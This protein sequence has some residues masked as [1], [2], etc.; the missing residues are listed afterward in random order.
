MTRLLETV[1]LSRRQFLKGAGA[2]VVTF[3]LPVTLNP[4]LADAAEDKAAKE[5]I[6]LD[7]VDSWLAIGQDGSITA[8]VGKV[9]VGMGI[10]TA[11]MQIVAEE[12]DVPLERV[13]ILMGDTETTPDQG[14][15]GSSNGIMTGGEA[16]RKAAAHAHHALLELAATRLNAPVDQLSVKD[17]VVSVQAAPTKHV[18]YGELIGGKRFNL[19]VP[20]KVKTKDPAQYTVVGKP[21]KRIDIPPI[22]TARHTYI[23]DVRVPGMLHGRI[24]RPPQAGA[25]PVSVDRSQKIPGLVKIVANKDFLAVVTEQEWQAVR[26]AREL[27]V[28]WSQPAARFPNSYEELYP[29]MAKMPIESSKKDAANTGDVDAALA[30]AAQTFEAVYEYPFQSHAS[31]GPACAIADV[32]NGKATVWFGGQKPYRV[33]KAIAELLAIPAKNVRVLWYPGPGSYGTNDADDAAA[34]AALLSHAIGKPVR[35]QWMRAEGTGWDPKGPAQIIRMRGGL[36]KD[37]NAVAWDFESR[38]FSG[39]LRAAGALTAGD[40]LAGEL[41]GFNPPGADEF[42]LAAESYR[43]PAKR[44]VSH[45]L[46]WKQSLGT[47][48]R[49]AHLRDPNGMQS[50]LASESFIDELAAAAGADPVEFRVRYLS[51]PRHVAIIKAAAKQAGWETRPSPKK[52][53][54]GPIVTGRG[55]AYAPRNGTYVATVAEVEVDKNT[56]EVRVKRFVVAHDCGFIINPDG[57]K[58][59]IEANLIQSMSRAMYEQ[60]QFD[61]HSVKSVDWMSYPIIDMTQVPDE[62]DIVLVNNTPEF[63]A[64]GAGEPS[65]RPTAAAIGNA[66]FDATGVRL[67]RVPFTPESVKAALKQYA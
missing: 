44:K 33:R 13:T 23:V 41:L 12:L 58:G 22:V 51:D 35:V 8:A 46:P 9:E 54:S 24:I 47:G 27:K 17:G 26:A 20:E 21:I 56:G 16:L 18:S 60:V 53:N 43:F 28:N 6:P 38:C 15:T 29:A 48:L 45:I 59:T 2:L 36:D 37:R 31:M 65:T 7:Q 32:R 39:T 67:R 55:I 52:A 10:S 19:T 63:P 5:K 34:D 25:N 61:S 62:I 11:F 1:T 57:L 64:K 14:G 3:G 30:A 50:C 40:T 49:T 4:K 66:I 42:S